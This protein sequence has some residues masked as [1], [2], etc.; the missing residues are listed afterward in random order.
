MD[1]LNGI[2]ILDANMAIGLEKLASHY[3]V[4][5]MHRPWTLSGDIALPGP[6]LSTID[7]W[8]TSGPDE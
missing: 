8:L 6:L 2:L 1:A 3:A 7:H 5:D 4:M